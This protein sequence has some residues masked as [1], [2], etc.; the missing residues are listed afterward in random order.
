MAGQ[1]VCRSHGGASPQARRAAEGRIASTRAVERLDAD[2]AE[3]QL[4]GNGVLE[5]AEYVAAVERELRPGAGATPGAVD[6]WI[7]V[8]EFQRRLVETIAKSDVATL[9]GRITQA[10]VNRLGDAWRAA[11]DELHAYLREHLPDETHREVDRVFREEVPRLA[12]KHIEAHEKSV[13]R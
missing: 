13:G 12:R 3:P 10:W 6:S 5:H 8:S 1:Q 7:K 11:T 9:D 2:N 4:P